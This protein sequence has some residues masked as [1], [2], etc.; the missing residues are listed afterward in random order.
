MHDFNREVS[1]QVLPLTV[2]VRVKGYVESNDPAAHATYPK[3]TSEFE[4]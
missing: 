4:L 3:N 2:G 1:V